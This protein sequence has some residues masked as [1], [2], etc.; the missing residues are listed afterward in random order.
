MK[1]CVE[2]LF[3]DDISYTDY[4]HYIQKIKNKYNNDEKLKFNRIN[5]LRDYNVGEILIKV[6]DKSLTSYFFNF[7]VY[8]FFSVILLGKLYQLI[9][10]EFLKDEYNY[11]RE[12][13]IVVRKIVSTRYNITSS[14]LAK[15]FNILNPCAYC[16]NKIYNFDISKTEF[17]CHNVI[18][19]K[20][21]EDELKHTS[22]SE[23]KITIESLIKRGK[24]VKINLNEN[25]NE[26]IADYLIKVDQNKNQ[27]SGH[28]T[29]GFCV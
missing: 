10:S 17:V 8:L 4:L 3:G 23:I 2:I 20:P 29:K 5:Q 26:I 24:K 16:K 19:I 14:E 11:E 7:Y 13:V 25:K 15:E 27:F 9:F 18:P 28:T 21:T 1:I 6:D 22:E 12:N